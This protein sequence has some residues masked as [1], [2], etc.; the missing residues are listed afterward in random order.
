MESRNSVTLAHGSQAALAMTSFARNCSSRCSRCPSAATADL[1]GKKLARRNP[2]I[3]SEELQ[4][5]GW[6]LEA[7]KP[8]RKGNPEKIKIARR[9]RSQTT[10]TLAWTAQHLSMGAPGSPANCL[11]D[12]R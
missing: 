8:R 11:R 10:M 4:K 6:D 7:L 12:K 5:L 1:N 3:L 9:L 2:H